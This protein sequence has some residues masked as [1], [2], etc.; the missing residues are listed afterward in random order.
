[1]ELTTKD[2]CE[3]IEVIGTAMLA[4]D[5]ESDELNLFTGPKLGLDLEE[6]SKQPAPLKRKCI[7]A[8]VLL[9]LF[10]LVSYGI[11]KV[12][13]SQLDKYMKLSGTDGKK[14]TAAML[15]ERQEMRKKIAGQRPN[16]LDLLTK[17][18]QSRPEGMLLDSFNYNK[19]EK[20]VTIV[21]T[22][23]SREQLFEFEQTLESKS[24][25][26]NVTPVERSSDKGKVNFQITFNYGKSGK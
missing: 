1:M 19:K 10:L 3:Y 22:A 8:G 2:V 4:I 21:S 7:M 15:I 14:M 20:K 11:T 25:I 5:A 17:I 23:N 18:N 9:V 6:K 24:G 26:S 13:L 12:R 16:L